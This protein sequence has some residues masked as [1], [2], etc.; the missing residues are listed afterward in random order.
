MI[1]CVLKTYLI[2]LKSKF[3]H[4]IA[5]IEFRF[6]T[7]VGNFIQRNKQQVYYLIRPFDIHIGH[8][9]HAWRL[10]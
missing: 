5:F 3:N 2:A 7:K 1:E 4:V 10:S 8:N 6:E 9:N